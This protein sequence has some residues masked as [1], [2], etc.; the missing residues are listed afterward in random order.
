MS[1]SLSMAMC[2][3]ADAFHVWRNGCGSLTTNT[4]YTGHHQQMDVWERVSTWDISALNTCEVTAFFQLSPLRLLKS[5]IY[6]ATF[7]LL[8]KFSN[9]PQMRN[10]SFLKSNKSDMWYNLTHSAAIRSVSTSW[11]AWDMVCMCRILHTTYQQSSW[12]KRVIGSGATQVISG[13]NP[14]GKVGG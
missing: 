5:I 13:Q 4:V 12:V 3:V 11:K 2:P 14:W 7:V 9:Y 8:Y 1:G 6:Y 10:T